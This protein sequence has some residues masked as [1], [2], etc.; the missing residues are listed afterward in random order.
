MLSSTPCLPETHTQREQEV[1]L[2]LSFTCQ[3]LC[4]HLFC[5]S[6]FS[7]R[8]PATWKSGKLLSIEVYAVQRSTA[9]DKWNEIEQD[10]TQ[11]LQNMN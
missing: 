10:I 1:T 8:T 6:Q 9:K 11:Y 5:K 7:A 2:C 3:V 4:A